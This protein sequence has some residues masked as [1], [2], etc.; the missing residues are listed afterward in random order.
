[1][2][3][4]SSRGPLGWIVCCVDSERGSKASQKLYLTKSRESANG[5]GPRVQIACSFLWSLGN[6]YT[7][8]KLLKIIAGTD[9]CQRGDPLTNLATNWI[10]FDIKIFLYCNHPSWRLTPFSRQTKLSFGKINLFH[11]WWSLTPSSRHLSNACL[12][13]ARKRKT[14]RAVKAR[15][16]REYRR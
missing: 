16:H 9:T 14:E 13:I 2:T 12:M 8:C 10:A 1:M 15:S 4:R 6:Y 7:A 3:V 5:F 11:Y